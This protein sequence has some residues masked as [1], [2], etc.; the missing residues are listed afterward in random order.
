MLV[1]FYLYRFVFVTIRDVTGN[2]KVQE[3]AYEELTF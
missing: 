2:L 3:I 1:E